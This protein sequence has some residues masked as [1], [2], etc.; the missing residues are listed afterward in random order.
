VPKA[1]GI[2]TTKASVVRWLKQ[3]GDAVKLGEPVVE[4]ETEKMSYELESPAEGVLLKILKRENSEVPVGEA[5]C[6]IGLA[7]TA[8]PG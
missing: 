8:A 7:G 1:G 5:L 4:L 6:Q 3:E 2:P